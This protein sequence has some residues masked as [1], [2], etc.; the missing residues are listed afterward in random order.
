MILGIIGLLITLYPVAAALFG[1]FGLFLLFFVIPLAGA[2]LGLMAIIIQSKTRKYLKRRSMARGAIMTKI[3]LITGIVALVIG[4][5]IAGA[6]LYIMQDTRG[7]LIEPVDKTE[8][9]LDS[10]ERDS[11]LRSE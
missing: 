3:G 9:Y 1:V 8:I 2:F 5:S 11:S 4:C 10:D 6:Y 7:S